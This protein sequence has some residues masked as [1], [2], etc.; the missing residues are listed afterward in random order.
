[1]FVGVTDLSIGPASD[2]LHYSVGIQ[3]KSM[4]AH[5]MILRLNK[6]GKNTHKKCTL[7]NKLRR[8]ALARCIDRKYEMFISITL[9]IFGAALCHLIFFF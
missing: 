1:M 9:N 8:V 4:D 5:C 3:V 6:Q 7:L 2:E